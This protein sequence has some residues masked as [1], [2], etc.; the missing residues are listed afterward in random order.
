[1]IYIYTGD[2]ICTESILELSLI[3][4]LI[5]GSMSASSMFSS[6]S[7]FFLASH[8]TQSSDGITVSS[9]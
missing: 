1:M 2:Q 6:D 8:Y 4:F 3:N 9:I 7:P 5:L